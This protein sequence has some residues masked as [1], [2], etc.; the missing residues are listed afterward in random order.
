MFG[1]PA[2]PN[3]FIIKVVI[4]INYTHAHSTKIGVVVTGLTFVFIVSWPH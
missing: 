3:A 4:L 1:Y 2:P